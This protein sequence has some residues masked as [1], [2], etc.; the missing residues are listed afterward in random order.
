[1]KK[2]N[3]LVRHNQKNLIKTK[4]KSEMYLG[5]KIIAWSEE[6]E[7]LVKHCYVEPDI[8]K[9]DSAKDEWKFRKQIIC[10][11]YRPD[12]KNQPF[13]ISEC[14]NGDKLTSVNQA[15][16]QAKDFMNICN[17]NNQNK[18]GENNK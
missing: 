11:L 17:N 1:M 14:L 7:E 16:N 8:D 3:H 18:E 4:E 5:S 12:S 2:H 10:H 15:I 9:V 6:F 13:Y